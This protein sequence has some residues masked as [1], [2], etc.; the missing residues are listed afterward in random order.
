MICDHAVRIIDFPHECLRCAH[1]ADS[2]TQ[3]ISANAERASSPS[4]TL[5]TAAMYDEFGLP[6]GGGRNA[7]AGTM[8]DTRIRDHAVLLFQTVGQYKGPE[9]QGAFANGRVVP[10]VVNRPS[11][12]RL[13]FAIP[14]SQPPLEAKTTPVAIV[15]PVVCCPVSSPILFQ[16]S[17]SKVMRV[18]RSSA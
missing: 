14:D 5:G 6:L 12:L 9:Y 10:W 4:L 1:Q 13:L 8:G 16:Y 18:S 11:R 3:K 17:C 7:A 2:V 15:K